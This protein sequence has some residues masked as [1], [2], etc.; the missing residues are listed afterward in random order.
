MAFEKESDQ[1]AVLLLDEADSFLQNRRQADKHWQVT[2]VNQF[3]TSLERYEGYVVCT[4]N[5]LEG[6][7]PAALRRFDFKL[8]FGTMNENQAWKLVTMVR[9]L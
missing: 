8:K 1:G 3:L 6:L 5:L 9:V 2:K 7:D 4:T